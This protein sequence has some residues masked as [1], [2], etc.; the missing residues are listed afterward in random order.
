MAERR[1]YLLTSSGLC[2]HVS[3]MEM[4]SCNFA[5]AQ[6]AACT[7]YAHA[8]VFPIA[9]TSDG[10][11]NARKNSHPSAD[12]LL[13]GPTAAT[14][15]KGGR[16]MADAPQTS[17]CNY[18]QALMQAPECSASAKTAHS[19]I[20]QRQEYTRSIKRLENM[21]ALP[22]LNQKR[23]DDSRSQHPPKR[24]DCGSR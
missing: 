11:E 16:C 22:R 9:F 12:G 17:V 23:Y 19:M 3:I 18:L 6:L 1:R 21:I 14:C 2:R 7:C 4:P 13:E 20:E 5:S 8:K 15:E 24:I 10:T